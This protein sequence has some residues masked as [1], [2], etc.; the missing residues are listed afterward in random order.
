MRKLLLICLLLTIACISFA[1]CPFPATISSTGNCT[2]DT[3]KVSTNSPL[4]QIQW[5]NNSTLVKTVTTPNNMGVT[6][7]GGNGAG[8][9]SNQFI[10][11]TSVFIDAAGNIYVTDRDNDRVQKW[12]P[13]ATTG[14]TVAGGNGRGANANQFNY[15]CATFVDPNGNIY[16]SDQNNWRV[17]KWAPNST[18]GITVAGGN[19]Y[20]TAANQFMQPWGLFIDGSG[21]L[22]VVDQGADRVQKFP[23]GSTSATNGTTVAG[24]N[25]ASSSASQ[26]ANPVGIYVDAHGNIYVTDNG[27]NRVQEW[28]PGASVG[29]TV[30]GGNGNGSNANQFDGCT[31]IYV[32]GNGNI[33]V[34]D[35]YNNRIQE[36]PPGAS[37]GITV[38][39]GKGYG[40]GSA[41][42]QLTMPVGVVVD[43]N[44][45]IYIA[46]DGNDRIQKWPP[47]PLIETFFIPATPGVYSAVVTNTSGCSSSTDSIIINPSVTPAIAINESPANICS[48][49]YVFTTAVLNAGTTPAYAWQVNGL[50]V[51]VNSDSFSTSNLQND[52]V[53]TCLLTSN[54]SCAVKPT[55]TSNSIKINTSPAVSLKNTGS[56]CLGNSFL[57]VIA[58]GNISQIIWYNENNTIDTA[59]AVDTVKSGTTVAGG[60]G[61]GAGGNQLYNPHSVWL[62]GTGNI[63]IADPVSNRIQKWL[64]GAF[65]GVTAAGGNG[66]GPASN[67]LGNPQGI[68]IDDNGN[69]YVAD[70]YNN[71][72]QKFPPGSDINTNAV[73]VAGGNGSGFAANQFSDPSAVYVDAAGNIYV[74]DFFNNRIQKWAPGAVSG[75]TIAGG[76]GAGSAANQ[77]SNP[78]DVFVD[79]NGNVYVAD[80]LNNRIQKFLPGS[81]NKTNGITVA[82]GNGAGSSANQL[83]APSGVFVDGEG[84]IYITDIN[85]YRV[86]K[87][88]PGATSGITVAGGNSGGTAQNQLNDPEGLYVDNAGNIYVADARNDRIQKW[89]QKI[90]IDTSFTPVAAGIYTAMVTNNAG[91]TF[92]T[93]AIT[94]NAA[95]APVTNINASAKSICNGDSVIFTASAINGGTSPSYQWQINNNS[96]GNNDSIFITSSL[97]NGDTITCMVSANTACSSPVLSTNYIAI[98]VKPVPV[99][100]LAANKTI[101]LGNSVQLPASVTGGDITNYL[102][103]PSTGLDNPYIINPAA[104]PVVTTTYKLNV[105]SANGCNAN[106]SITVNVFIKIIVPNAFSPNGDGINDTWNITHLSDYP[107]CT[108]DVFNRYGQLLFHTEGYA[109]PWDGTYNNKPLPAGTYYYIINPKNGLQQMAGSVTILR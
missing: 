109:K 64:P 59:I 15:A 66:Q 14:I 48:G 74:A 54:A 67:Q 53:V 105:T 55:V 96:A 90:I 39:G 71:R 42:D 101:F 97:I 25:G 45:N 63:Y 70:F 21:N 31:G 94:I 77:F 81:D 29:I 100:S 11:P 98:E 43:G 13:G 46:D 68:F 36:W 87:W 106:D 73:T 107:G 5:Y 32:D 49:S 6:V 61:S 22:Y 51:N 52:D 40:S 78:L 85:N 23:P 37:A 18:T 104:S 33:Y 95:Y 12:V 27:N 88:A 65:S 4:T 28:A 99:I 38:A 26:L 7:A 47:Q 89:A 93:N 62:D 34:A 79:K 69:L 60:N 83:N 102:W 58:T 92:T 91:C 20:G 16:V 84:N 8:I 86:Q 56:N 19:G 41:S 82:G 30:A 10:N 76:N 108:V 17:Q 35:E 75:I 44:G 103:S 24:G 3:I 1:Q 80:E 50:N 57:N 2:G 72:I 9:S